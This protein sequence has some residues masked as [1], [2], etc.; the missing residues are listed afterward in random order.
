MN[1]EVAGRSRAEWTRNSRPTRR[2]PYLV[3]AFVLVLIAATARPAFGAR[4]DC[5]EPIDQSPYLTGNLAVSAGEP[6]ELR[7][8]LRNC[9][10]TTW[11]APAWT[12][13]GQ[14]VWRSGSSIAI[15]LDPLPGK[16]AGVVPQL[17]GLQAYYAHVTE[18]VH[19]DGRQLRIGDRVR[20]GELIGYG[21]DPLGHV[22][23][24]LKANGGDERYLANTLDPSTYYGF[25]PGTLQWP[26]CGS[27]HV[28]IPF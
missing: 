18:Q 1:P 15:A 28:P 23:S 9:G 3:V 5:A 17:V 26:H 16:Y 7:F 27:G 2:T 11:S 13:R 4:G 14:V 20:R 21:R 19:E 24:S 8:R 6:I 12:F 22:H 25:S 10:S